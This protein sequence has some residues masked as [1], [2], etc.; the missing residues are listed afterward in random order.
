M[1]FSEAVTNA[2]AADFEVT[3]TTA[4]HTLADVAGADA[5]D[6]TVSGGDLDSLDA[7]VA[8]S[9]A[10]GQDIVDAADNALTNV[11]PTGANEDSYTVDNSAPS[12]PT[13]GGAAVNGT[14]LV[15]TF[16][17]ALDAASVPETDTFKVTVD[18]GA[19]TEP[20]A[21]AIDGAV[22]TLTL[23]TAVTAAQAV[24]VRYTAPAG[25]GAVGLRD[26]AGNA[27]AS[28]TAA[29]TVANE[30]G[31]TVPGAP[32]S[33]A[34]NVG[35]GG[36]TLAWE[37]PAS[38]GGTAVTGYEYR[39]R[40]ESETT[41]P[42]W[43]AVAAEAR[44]AAVSGLDNDTLYRFE[45][46]AVNQQ[47][48][49]EAADTTATPDATT[50]NAPELAGRD[51]VWR[52][53]LT[54]GRQGGG[55]S[56][57]LV[58]YGWYHTTG[59]LSGRSDSIEIGANR[60]RIGEMVLLYAHS[61]DLVGLMS[62]VPGALVF[63][64]VGESDRE[65]ELT[66]AEKAALVL[67]VCAREF[68]FAS[69]TRVGGGTAVPGPGQ[70]RHYVWNGAA[71]QWSHGLMRTLVLSKPTSGGARSAVSV[72]SVTE[73]TG[74]GEDAV[75]A[76][77][78]R[79]EVRVRFS[80]PVAVDASDG[81]PTLGIALGGVRREAAWLPATGA[82]AQLI[83]ALTVA[84]ADAGAEAAKAIAN[85]IRL[86]GGAI[87]DTAGT[88]A[89]FDYGE[90]PGVVSVEVAPAPGDDG[91]WS[92]GEAVEVTLAFAEP[93]DVGTAEG[94]PSLGLQLPGAGARRANHSGGS[95]T[96]R[97]VFAYTPVAADGS[98]TAV[99]VDAD[100][101][102]LNGGTIVSTGGLDAVLAH[103]G[104][105]STVGPR[106]PGPALSV[107]DTEGAEGATL[108]FQVTLSQP[109]P[110]AVTVAYTTRDGAGEDAAVAGE[111][112]TAASGTLSFKPGETQKSVAVTVTDDGLSEGAETLTLHL[113]GAQGAGIADG[114]ATGTIAASASAA[115]LTAAFVAVPPE[116]DGQSAF[117]VEL[118]FSEAPAQMSYR[119]VRD[120]LFNVSGGDVKKAR[121]LNPP[122][123]Q[124]FE[125]TV[126][127]TGNAAAT[128]ELAT[129]LPACGV[130][131]SVCTADGRTLEGPFS[132]TVPGPA[133]LSVA[134]AEVE[135]EPGATLAFVV[136]L[137]RTRHAPVTVDYTTADGTAVAG[138]DYTATSG[139]LAF[140]AGE[141]E[142]TVSVPVLDDSHDEGS[143]TLTLSLSDAE[144]AAIDDGMATG[145]IRN[146]DPLPQAWLARF[147]R[148]A[149][150]H[151]IDAI[152]WRVQATGEVDEPVPHLTFGGRRLD[153]LITALGGDSPEGHSEGRA[154]ADPL[155]DES[156]WAR[157]DRLREEL[158]AVPGFGGEGAFR[159][160]P[161]SQS[162]GS[163]LGHLPSAGR[164]FAGLGGGVFVQGAQPPG[165]PAPA[166]LSQDGPLQGEPLQGEPPHG[167]APIQSE[168]HG[169][170]GWESALDAIAAAAGDARW[171]RLYRE[172][173]SLTGVGGRLPL[174]DALMGSS[175]FY[176][177]APNSDGEVAGPLGRWAVWGTTSATRF[178]GAEEELSINGDV[179]TATLGFDTQR[180]R[181]MAGLA[182][183]YS[184]GRGGY[185]HPES[186]VGAIHS[187][188]TQLAPYARFTVNERTSLWGT[189][190]YGTG[191]MTL[192]P[193]GAAPAGGTEASGA[194]PPA[195]A[196]G[197][198]STMAG[199]GGRAEL[200][201]SLAGGD[202]ALAVVSDA[203]F[204]RTVSDATEG[205][206]GA[207]GAASRV[208]LMLE[209]RGS[210]ALGQRVSLTP[211]LQAGL[212][213]DGGD[214]ETGAGIEVVAGL[215]MS[216]GSMSVQLDAR[217]LLA[218]QDAAYEEWGL[219]ASL[220]YRPRPDGTGLSVTMGSA[221]GATGN[222]IQAMWAQP[223]AGG[224]ANG[225]AAIGGAHR[226][227]AELAYGFKGPKDRALWAPFV[228]ADAAAG[229]VPVLRFGA[230]M[231]AEPHARAELEITREASVP[232][233]GGPRAGYAIRVVGS[234][235]W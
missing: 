13:T 152:G 14:A 57:E 224:L 28:D 155:A 81:A 128:L 117:T 15:L 134:D 102:A 135:E 1:T 27:V 8:L 25:Q 74:P 215:G 93:V 91:T 88:D 232:G 188:L 182:L 212:R 161:D 170:S 151:T 220:T 90:A 104:A 64:L 230:R 107:A 108:A 133:A 70:D 51:E 227:Q 53:T 50:C 116:H 43:T 166:G 26:A 21:V 192:S 189:L 12:L 87:R 199:L 71:L 223:H 184:D 206:M 36:V 40:K 39:Y 138:E 65:A 208:R 131:G 214:A 92:E 101:L 229:S 187:T 76:K 103:N 125:I 144:G 5:V 154:R 49:G 41:W 149:T 137:D 209:G 48:A 82:A 58:G 163:P 33:L 31:A 119:T 200:S 84:E 233:S 221:W 46:R 180:G 150:D 185:T 130:S 145:T 205:M 63:H 179:A 191:R 10:S 68:A 86:N 196:A 211:T 16:G 164:P 114:D 9:F 127:P 19:E 37:A 38:D 213:Y 197:L 18:G 6:V 177:P 30:T 194:A 24:T 129:D 225:A 67:H 198:A 29:R 45:L 89:V 61:G 142:K 34:A 157:M 122:S 216:A 231:T 32:A 72:E 80:A 54:V 174:R 165:M 106:S 222:G 175:F 94:T 186:P 219:G 73:P 167:T 210:L 235:L 4:T 113:S 59:A 123:N 190:G 62:P 143:E 118:H 121:R 115:A 112:Y 75:Y 195:L 69:A 204:S 226:V 218:H 159:S 171:A 207:A 20:S 111:D 162:D 217:G 160:S 146:S 168:G 105:G 139:A 176:A 77:D 7:T 98:V 96:D 136:S 3:G 47:G 97:L 99:L 79:I 85:G 100:S 202:L 153:A 109:A 173:R 147:G 158:S 234:I 44:Q 141:T 83:F 120:T 66:D 35:D 11:V 95:G 183:S 124:G 169:E 110:T 228:A 60:Y 148:T 140:A 203:R 193:E 55:S 178:S 56:N 22:V 17:E 126:E 201:R 172:G 2:D 132:V 78:D 42:A 156:A 52:G 181:W 23:A